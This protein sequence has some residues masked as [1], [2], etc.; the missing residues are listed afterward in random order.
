MSR[1]DRGRALRRLARYDP[2][3]EPGFVIAFAGGIV[4]GVM[5]SIAGALI[6][7]WWLS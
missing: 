3:A 4:A 6:A 7:G 2:G 1:E 5:L